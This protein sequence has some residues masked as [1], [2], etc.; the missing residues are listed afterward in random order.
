[1]VSV[2]PDLSSAPPGI[3]LAGCYVS[4]WPVGTGDVRGVMRHPLPGPSRQAGGSL[5]KTSAALPDAVTITLPAILSSSRASPQSWFALLAS[6]PA[7][8]NR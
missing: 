5:M 2:S 7:H 1:M 4:G 3:P 6:P 8:A